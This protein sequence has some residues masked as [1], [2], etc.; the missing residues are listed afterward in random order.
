MPHITELNL[1]E[2]NKENIPPFM[3]HNN[4]NNRV[5]YFDNIGDL[6]PRKPLPSP[7]RRL[8][9]WHYPIALN[10]QFG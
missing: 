9:I 8:S 2:D 3:L 7:L 5:N 1:S 6:V 4:L 10:K